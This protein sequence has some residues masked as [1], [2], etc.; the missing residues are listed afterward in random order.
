MDELEKNAPKLS[1][2]KKENPFGTP[3]KYFDDFSARLQMKLETEKRAVPNQ[4]NRII[5]F[6]KP[7][8][9]L[10]ASFALIFMLVYWPLKTFVPNEVSNNTELLDINDM[11]YR[12]NLEGIDENSF[13]TLLEEPTNS[14]KF[15]DED[16]IS[17]VRTNVSEYELY[18]A[19]NY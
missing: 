6:L 8:L 10:A 14:I 19:T 2:L 1:K 17:Y 12:T 11:Q 3:D 15:S 13:Y 5:Q 4:Q 18:L 9:G 7:A 16:L